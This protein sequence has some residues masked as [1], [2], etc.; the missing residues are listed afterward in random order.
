VGGALVREANF[1]Q[2]SIGRS[3][4]CPYKRGA[5]VIEVP[6]HRGFTVQKI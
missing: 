1:Q 5:L 2:K 6:I 4:E 3:T